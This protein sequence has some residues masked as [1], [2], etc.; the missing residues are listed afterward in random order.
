[1]CPPQR[2]RAASGR[3]EHSPPP[4]GRAARGPRR[5]AM[6]RR[7]AAPARPIDVARRPPGWSL[8]ESLQREPMLHLRQLAIDP[9]RAVPV[10]GGV[11]PD[12]LVAL[13]RQDALDL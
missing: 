1:M 9:G 12:H 8:L 6:Q 10:T 2:T 3:T 13:D 11:G 5:A 4:P 7:A